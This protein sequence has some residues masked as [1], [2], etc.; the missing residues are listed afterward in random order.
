MDDGTHHVDEEEGGDGGENQA[1]EVTGQTN[2]D[3]TVP[4][5][6]AESLPQS[7]VVRGGGEGSLLLAEAWD[8]EVN[9]SAHLSLDLEALDHLDNLAL[10]LVSDRVVGAVLAQILS[11]IVL[12]TFLNGNL[13]NYKL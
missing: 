5:E 4:L 3:L 2:V 7:A 10:L 12:H 11:D 13:I 6:R 1:H 8:I 9:A